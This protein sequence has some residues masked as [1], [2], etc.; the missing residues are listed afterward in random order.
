LDALNQDK[1]KR[2]YMSKTTNTF[3]FGVKGRGQWIG[4]DILILG[5][6]D[7]FYFSVIAVGRVQV[8]EISKNDM[9]TKLP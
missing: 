5:S 9:L 4:E 7:P 1:K 8:I 6:N 2:G 3:Q